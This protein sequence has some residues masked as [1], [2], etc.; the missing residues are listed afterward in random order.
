MI[1]VVI[2]SQI[3]HKVERLFPEPFDRICIIRIGSAVSTRRL[4]RLLKP[5]G[6][7]YILAENINSNKLPGFDTSDYCDKLLLNTFCQ[8]VLNLPGNE[9]KV[10][11][12]LN[13]EELLKEQKR[14]VA[15]A[16]ETVIC[17]E[18]NADNLCR[19]FLKEL[20][21]CPAIVSRKEQLCDC[22]VIFAPEGI[23]GTSATVFDRNTTPYLPKDIFP[24]Y[25]RE[26]L[27]KDVN[28]I[29]LAAILSLVEPSFS[30]FALTPCHKHSLNKA[31]VI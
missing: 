7:D 28:P 6:N 5:F 22:D 20:G 17:T 25:C 27:E 1:A 3:G 26:L 23:T 29:K 31:L 16:A 19:E 8:F 4:K 11:I 10:G 30:P 13:D 14:V 2:K 9:L 12:C 24:E 15:H 21:V 18:S